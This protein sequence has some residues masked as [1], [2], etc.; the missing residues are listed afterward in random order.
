[1]INQEENILSKTLDYKSL[2]NLTFYIVS[3]Y[4]EGKPFKT[5]KTIV[6]IGHFRVFSLFKAVKCELFVKVV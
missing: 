2:F 1:M 5:R 3:I 6:S 4:R